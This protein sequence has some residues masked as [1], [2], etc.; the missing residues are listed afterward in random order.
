MA[1]LATLIEFTLEE[2]AVVFLYFFSPVF[3]SRNLS[4]CSYFSFVFLL[5][6]SVV[7]N[8]RIYFF[9]SL[10]CIWDMFTLQDTIICLY[11]SGETSKTCVLSLSS[12]F[13]YFDFIFFYL[14]LKLYSSLNQMSGSKLVS[15]VFQLFH[16]L[17]TSF[18][19]PYLSSDMSYL[20]INAFH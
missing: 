3:N 11:Y 2:L 10:K 4:S 19:I 18:K 7:Q 12:S 6:R 5:F 15:L 9:G 8:Q 14:R 20:S 17:F 16:L 1:V 13:S